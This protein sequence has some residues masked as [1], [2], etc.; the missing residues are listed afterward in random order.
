MPQLQETIFVPVNQLQETIIV[1]VHANDLQLA[2]ASS[3]PVNQYFE[4]IFQVTEMMNNEIQSPS[5][6]SVTVHWRKV[7]DML[8]KIILT[9]PKLEG[10]YISVNEDSQL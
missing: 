6:E 10:V 4:E 3:K 7:Y 9:H 8:K 1:K 2:C 5:I